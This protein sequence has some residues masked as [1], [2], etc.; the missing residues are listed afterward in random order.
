MDRIAK[1]LTALLIAFLLL[2]FFAPSQASAAGLSPQNRPIQ[3]TGVPDLTITKTH[4]GNFYQGQT[5]ATYTIKVKNEGTVATTG[6][7]TVKDT[8]PAGLT[9]TS[10][11]GSGWTCT[12]ATLT[13][14]RS[15]ALDPGAT[16]PN[17]TLKVTVSPSAGSP[18][19]NTVTVSGGGETNT[20]NN[21]ATDSTIIEIRPYLTATKT[22]TG[23]FYQGQTNASYTVVVTNNG[24]IPTSGTVTL[25]D[26]VSGG[27]EYADIY[28]T[29]W[30]CSNL[31]NRTCTRSDV[32]AVGASYPPVTV[33]VNVKTDAATPQTNTVSVSGGNSATTTYQDSTIIDPR[34]DLRITQA[35]NL[36]EGATNSTIS[37]T[38]RNI[39][40]LAIP[41]GTSIVVSDT[42]PTEFT[43]TGFTG[44]GWSCSI[45]GQLV[46]CNRSDGL[47]GSTQYPNIV[48]TVTVADD[49][50]PTVTNAAT[51]NVVPDE[52]YT[53]NNRVEGP[54]TV[55]QV[56]DLTITKDHF[57][58]FREGATG[59][60]TI[61]VNNI[62][63]GPTVGIIYITDTLPTGMTAIAMSGTGW[64][65][66]PAL[67]RCT[68]TT[69]V[70]S[71]KSAPVILLTVQL[72]ND[73]DPLLTN[74]VVTAGGGELAK[75]T[76]NNSASDP[77]N[78]IQVADLVV[79]KSHTGN[80]FQGQY[81]ATYTILV[82]NAGDG[83]SD[84]PVSLVDTLPAGM[85][86]TDISGTGWD[87]DLPSLTC[88][89][90]DVLGI[91][92]SYD[93]IT[94]LVDVA[95]NA[96]ATLIN[97]ATASGGGEAETSNSF[98]DD[99]TTVEPRPDITVI[100]THTGNF[101]QGKTGTY[102]LTVTNIG[103][104]ATDG[105]T[106][107]TLVDTLPAGLTATSI[108]GTSW[109]CD[110]PSLT[111]TRSDVLAAGDSYDLITLTVNVAV[112]APASV[113]N[114]ATASGG[115]E[116][117]TADNT[118]DDPTTVTQVADLSIDKAHA[119]DFRE[120]QQ[121]ALYTL[122][123]SNS[124]YGPT[125][126][127][128]TVVDTVPAGMTP[129]SANG[130][131]W[132]CGIV[133]QVVTCTIP[134][135]LPVGLS[136][137]AINLYVN[138]DI[139][140]PLS[141]TNSVEVSM[142]DENN[143]ANN[144]DSDPT[145]IIQVADLIIS[146]TST[147]PA[148]YSNFPQGGTGTYALVVTNNGDGPTDA[149]VTVTDILPVGL[150]ASSISGTGWNCAL[151]TVSCTRSDILAV[152]GSYD[153]IQLEV[154]VAPDSPLTVTN[155]A[156]VA[157]GGE[158]DT[159]NSTVSLPTT[160][161]PQ[162][163]LKVEKTHTDPFRQGQTGAT[164]TI[165]VSNNGD[166]AHTGGATVIDTLP[167]SLTFVSMSGTNWSCAANS[168]SR[169]DDLA[170]DASYE[171]II[172]TFDVPVDAPATVI[173]QADISGF[174]E[175]YLAD[176]TVQDLTNI[177][178]V[179]D[180]TITKT[181]TGDFRQ[182]QQGAEYAITVSNSA[183]NGFGPTDATVT[184]V[185]T[186]PGDM[187]PV[188][189]TGTG[190]SC[191]IVGQA[192]TCTNSTPLA[193]GASYP[194]I[195]LK[196]NVSKTSALSLTNNV[197]VSMPGENDTTDNSASD[198][199]NIIPVADMTVAKTHVG[200]FYQ[201]Q[202]TG[203]TYTIVVSNN[204]DGP[205]DAPV[206]VVDTLPAGLTTTAMSG[207]GWTC[208]LATRTCTR[209]D[210]LASSASYPPVTLTVSVSPDAAAT[211]TNNVAVSGGGE[212]ETGNN[213]DSDPTTVIP[214][215]DL[216]VV[217]THSGDFRQG[218]S[219]SFTI[220]V[221]NVG[222][223]PTTAAVSLVDTLP[224]GLTAASIGG[225][226]WTCN[227]GT[228][229]CTR[230]D[231]LAAGASYPAVVI[232]VTVAPDALPTVAN[233]VSV[234]MTGEV[235]TANN[236]DI[237]TVDTIPVADLLIDK[238]HTGD[239]RQGQQGAIYTLTVSNDGDGAT[240]AAVTVN[241]TLPAGLVPVGAAGTGWSCNIT[242]Q[243]V[244]CTR[245]N[246]LPP[247]QSYPAITITVNVDNHAAPNLTNTASVSMPL[248]REP[249]NNTG[250]DPTV[251][252][253]IADL[254][255]TKTHT[256]DFIQGQ[257]GRT[258]TIVVTNVGDGPTDAV[259]SLVD[260]LP[261]GLTATALNGLGWNCTLSTL[262]CTRSD[263]LASELSYPALT[264]TAS[265]AANA[266]ASLTN[267]VTISGGGEVIV[268]NNTASDPITVILRA[269]LEVV[270]T[271]NPLAAVPGQPVVYTIDFSNQG[272]GTATDVVLTDIL[273]DAFH[274]VNFTN[275][276][277][278]V[279]DSG[280]T[281]KF[282]WDVEDLSEGE[283]GR[284][285]INGYFEPGT[286]PQVITNQAAAV[287]SAIEA[288]PADNTDDASLEL[289]KADSTVTLVSNLTQA[290]FGD[291]I[292]L[293]ATA[294]TSAPAIGMPTG[295]ITFTN[296]STVMGQ[297]SLDPNG[298]AVLS[299]ATLQPGTYNFQAGYSGDATHNP[300]DSTIV[301]VVVR[302]VAD[303]AITITANPEDTILTGKQ[304]TYITKAINNGPNP[305]TDVTYSLTLPTGF[306]FD[307][308][309]SDP[310]CSAAGQVVTCTVG[311]LPTG[312]TDAG[313]VVATAGPSAPAG[314]LV[315][316]ATIASDAVH[317]PDASN[318]TDTDT[319]RVISMLNFYT[320][321]FEEPVGSEWCVDRRDV[322]PIGA[323]NFLGQFGNETACLT[324]AGLIPHQSITVEFDV[325]VIRSWNG[326]VS[327]YPPDDPIY[328]RPD[329]DET[330]VVLEPLD[331]SGVN[332]PDHFKFFM[333]AIEQ[334]HTSFSNLRDHPQSFPSWFKNGAFLRF[335]GAVEDR[336]LGYL[337]GDHRSDS[338][339]HLLFTIP[340]NTPTLNLYWMAEGLQGLENESW[341]I[342]N[343]SIT[344]YGQIS[345]IFLPIMT[346]K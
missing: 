146:K 43:P 310:S 34:K 250:S 59:V 251:I 145:T 231:A 209:S 346:M 329:P 135:A 52:F 155:N 270:K 21:T 126:G 38:V 172:V 311:A 300:S 4:T 200:D 106:A 313:W 91:G 303:L 99:P 179:A 201:G 190:W 56:A 249:S 285:T 263:V 247:T 76:G 223:A 1:N 227:L 25:L 178:Q 342:D 79:E 173:N 225:S 291:T 117:Y 60:Y 221:T 98:D 318:N 197:T 224:V 42:I 23:N 244:T 239:F 229:T 85:T 188:S 13:C 151:A 274:L 152:G 304:I 199:T 292:I 182:G 87:C 131:G 335:S 218:G 118:D 113:T 345:Q 241:D 290:I 296:G 153:P 24:S 66:D 208:T 166:A 48:V 226:G 236:S 97:T 327:D 92:A 207:T 264:L 315:A 185:D 105:F 177:T 255:V 133:G 72:A 256:G 262:T 219:G 238:A 271:A 128:V 279:T 320:E 237:D 281:P 143:T 58:D 115:G 332:G 40:T 67:V 45:V 195:T 116:V 234:S 295:T 294:Q 258:F 75:D 147:P 142:P 17:I 344:L 322:T 18:R 29:G 297:V 309:A 340:H 287:T 308:A 73:T 11:A 272:M 47:N 174:V 39:G 206:A 154:N 235:Y 74:N 277:A 137:P 162:P 123:V 180:L 273:P 96:G 141:V 316:T 139:H 158:A 51:V 9:A 31:N 230:A 2:S 175:L 159:A 343:V 301:V 102:T 114:S 167:A 266:Q 260:T 276:G 215:P 86:A 212:A 65:C 109:A 46:N 54:L 69:A 169:S 150:T 198:P 63:Q 41:A 325:F 248:E 127:L 104:L 165:L 170:I 156:E 107:V 7:V 130:T 5:G 314:N 282:V 193:L 44:T 80:F 71:T 283:S 83:P 119:S 3:Q 243:A 192:V 306:I 268:N 269:D 61:T 228:L 122:T 90:S 213:T 191:N 242:G 184:V 299:L 194:G 203:A 140:A 210:A 19:T 26:T 129:A 171:P 187:T 254:A 189:A 245:S 305:A 160:I 22:H 16:Y 50:D 12:L 112:D 20:S 275:T 293:T 205:T 216:T 204:G 120:G 148:G 336:T 149:P 261:A 330:D 164:Y 101:R 323:R 81:G 93:I 289:I 334:L 100:K 161:D 77:T 176:N 27:M 78:I 28:G 302:P 57:G 6:V 62:G 339:Y 196:V 82:S 103:G 232:A 125:D 181:H 70:A 326:N 252:T 317:D 55:R 319:I 280:A 163:N 220:T 15:S 331:P 222:D 132:T 124:G 211:V 338:V 136:Y 217:K 298:I 341:G 321:D 168:C 64:T 233:Q 284:I 32:L 111:C 144:S 84:A 108:S 134:N 183:P 278:L 333:E 246:A 312:G 121:G 49:T 14:T 33:L 110:L 240:D 328:A 35:S 286:L 138:V 253:Q 186:V 53:V 30:D 89:R 88:T 324:L 68:R 157:G 257:T 265:V 8:L 202:T 267:T 337:Y 288:N 94:L 259:V 36:R 95:P 10:L 214:K 37:L 307:P